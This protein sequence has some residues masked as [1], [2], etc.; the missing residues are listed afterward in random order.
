MS[1]LSNIPA[2][3]PDIASNLKIPSNTL[4]VSDE[5]NPQVDIRLPSIDLID[6]HGLK[7]F[8][9]LTISLAHQGLSQP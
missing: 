1:Y 4:I 2:L 7:L 8:A 9:G 5:S 3:F 6:E